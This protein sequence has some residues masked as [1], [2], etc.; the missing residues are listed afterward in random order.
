MPTDALASMCAVGNLLRRM[1]QGQLLED[2]RLA[3]VRA[4]AEQRRSEM[5]VPQPEP[6][7]FKTAKY[8]QTKGGT[9]DEL[10]GIPVIGAGAGAKPD[11]VP[12]IEGIRRADRR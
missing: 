8:E 1:A 9:P 12:H 6:K 4:V 2:Q 11:T 7:K 3:L 5:T 10:R